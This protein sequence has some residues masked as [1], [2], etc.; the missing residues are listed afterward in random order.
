MTLFPEWQAFDISQDLLDRSG[1]GYFKDRFDLFATCFIVPHE[2]ETFDGMRRIE[3]AA[4]LRTLY[5]NMLRFFSDNG[6]TDLHRRVVAAR[7]LSEDVIQSTH[8]TRLVGRSATLRDPYPVMSTLHRT[9]DGWKVAKGS[10]AIPRDPGH[11][12]A[13]GIPSGAR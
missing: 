4:E 11:Q 2:I 1:E 9:D 8:E 13:F 12:Q 3:D 10:Y 6:I 7:F 5:D